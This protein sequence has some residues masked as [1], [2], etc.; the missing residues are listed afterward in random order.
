MSHDTAKGWSAVRTD[1]SP[2]NRQA[3]AAF[4]REH[5]NKLVAVAEEME[6]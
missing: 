2:E 4:M 1:P 6:G 5:A 3:L